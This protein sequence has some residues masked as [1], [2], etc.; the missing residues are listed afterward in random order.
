MGKYGN[1]VT[2]APE[3]LMLPAFENRLR[4][5]TH[6]FVNAI[7][8]TCLYRARHKWSTFFIFANFSDFAMYIHQCI[9]FSGF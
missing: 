9:D 3:L 8:G 7:K 2:T 5:L 1:V 6:T 4:F